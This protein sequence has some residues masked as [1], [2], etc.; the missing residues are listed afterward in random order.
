VVVEG[1][2]RQAVRRLMVDQEVAHS[3]IK[4]LTMARAQRI[5]VMTA[6]L[7]QVATV[8]LE[9]EVLAVLVQIA[10]EMVVPVVL[11]WLQQLQEAPLLAQAVVAVV[12]TILEAILLVGADAEEMTQRTVTPQLLT[13]EAAAAVPQLTA[14]KML[15]GAMAALASLFCEWQQST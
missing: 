13:L 2:L 14:D 8:V 5:R 12:V 10:P 6:V 1:Q 4:P 7:C 15:Q 9:A 3:H 11:V